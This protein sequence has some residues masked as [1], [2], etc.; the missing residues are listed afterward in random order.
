MFHPTLWSRGRVLTKKQKSSRGH[1]VTGTVEFGICLE[2]SKASADAAR[3][4]QQEAT[5]RAN[6]FELWPFLTSANMSHNRLQSLPLGC[7]GWKAM[8]RLN[9]AGNLLSELP[10]EICTCSELE[11]EFNHAGPM[12]QKCFQVSESSF[13]L[14]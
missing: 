4:A 2:K 7:R 6:A 3:L 11:G 5:A 14:F 8:T 1:R 12:M 9:L 10:E 13:L